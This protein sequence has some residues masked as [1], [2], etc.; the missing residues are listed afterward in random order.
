MNEPQKSMPITPA[1]TASSQDGVVAGKVCPNC[2][3]PMNSNYPSI[4]GDDGATYCSLSC[5]NDAIDD[6]VSVIANNSLLG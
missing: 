1:P 6:D 4:T 3:K 5:A 2:N